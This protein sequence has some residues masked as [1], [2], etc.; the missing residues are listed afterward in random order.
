MDAN[1]HANLHKLI[2]AL[3]LEP[4]ARLAALA[5]YRWAMSQI[6]P[7]HPDVP[8]IVCRISELEHVC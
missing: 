5:Y 2:G 1:K 7:L 3:G 4:F 8:S 6:D